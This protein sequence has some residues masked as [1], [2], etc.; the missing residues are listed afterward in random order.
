MERKKKI[1]IQKKADQIT[2]YNIDQNNTVVT[3]EQKIID[4]GSRLIV[5]RKP[6]AQAKKDE[7]IELTYNPRVTMGRLRS[8]LDREKKRKDE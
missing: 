4:A 3:A 6:V 1:D 5:E 8:V 2:L 7:T